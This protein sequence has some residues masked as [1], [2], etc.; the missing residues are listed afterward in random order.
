MDFGILIVAKMN[1]EVA[2]LTRMVVTEKRESFLEGLRANGIR[3]ETTAAIMATV[4]SKDDTI[5]ETFEKFV[6]GRS[7]EK[8]LK[9][10]FHYIEPKS[11]PLPKGGDFQYVS[12]LET[13][14]KITRYRTFQA[15]LKQKVVVNDGS[16]RD[17]EDGTNFKL[18][19]YF[20]KNPNA[21]K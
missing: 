2:E 18:S 3:E 17:L 16:I 4:D 11:V 19:E 12:I 21:L 14:K 15:V 5:S 8:Y 9:D 6:S 10:N 20:R 7:I 1:T 13:L